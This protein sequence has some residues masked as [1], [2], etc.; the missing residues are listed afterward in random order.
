MMTVSY[1]F[2]LIFYGTFAIIDCLFLLVLKQDIIIS[3][4]LVQLREDRMA[5][6]N[7]F[8]NMI[9]NPVLY[10]FA[11]LSFAFLERPPNFS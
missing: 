8:V 7:P 1:K 9:D 3:K 4:Y 6:S 5:V 10:I 11:F 2:F